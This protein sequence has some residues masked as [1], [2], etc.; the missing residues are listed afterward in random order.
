MSR[1]LCKITTQVWVEDHVPEE[2]TEE[3]FL[4]L[5]DKAKQEENLDWQVEELLEDTFTD[6]GIDVDELGLSFTFDFS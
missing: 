6:A 3:D 1:R 2:F 4:R 5:L